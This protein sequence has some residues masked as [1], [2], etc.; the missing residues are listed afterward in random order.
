MIHL[1]RLVLAVACVLLSLSATLYAN[2]PTHRIP[3][4]L[5][6]KYGYKSLNGE[7]IIRAQFQSAEEFIGQYAIVQQRELWGI[8]NTKGAWVKDPIF[9]TLR[10]GLTS[11]SS[12]YYIASLS[13]RYGLIA[14]NGYTCTTALS[15]DYDAIY[16][17]EKGGFFT[18]QQQ[19]KQGLYNPSNSLTLGCR[20]DKIEPCTNGYILHN[21]GKLTFAGKSGTASDA[22][23]FDSI[24]PHDYGFITTINGHKGFMLPNGQIALSCNYRELIFDNEHIIA[25]GSNKCSIYSITSHKSVNEFYCDS[26]TRDEHGYIIA[27]STRSAFLPYKYLSTS[28][29]FYD[30]LTK[31]ETGYITE[32][33]GKYGHITNSGVET[34]EPMFSFIDPERMDES[35]LCQDG[36]GQLYLIENA[37][38]TSLMTYAEKHSNPWSLGLSISTNNSPET[39]SLTT[40]YYVESAESPFEEDVDEDTY[41][42]TQVYKTIKFNSGIT[43]HFV[44]HQIRRDEYYLFIKQNGQTKAKIYCN[45][46]GLT[47][48]GYNRGPKLQ[49]VTVL[50][51]GNIL[52]ESEYYSYSYNYSNFDYKYIVILDGSSFEVVNYRNTYRNCKVVGVSPNGGIYLGNSDETFIC[53]PNAHISKYSDDGE[54]MWEYYA[55]DDTAFTS[56]CETESYVYLGGYTKNRGYIG[57]QNPYIVVLDSQSGYYR[58]DKHFKIAN[59]DYGVYGFKNGKALVASYEYIN[60]YYYGGYWGYNKENHKYYDYLEPEPSTYTVVGVQH[61]GITAYGLLNEKRQWVITPVL[62]GSEPKSFGHWTIHPA[63]TDFNPDTHHLEVSAEPRVEY[64]GEYITP[65]D[66]HPVDEVAELA[67]AYAE[68]VAIEET[69][70]YAEPAE[71]IAEAAVAEED[72]KWAVAEECCCCGEEEAEW[73]IAEQSHSEFGGFEFYIVDDDTIIELSSLDDPIFWAIPTKTE[74]NTLTINDI[75]S[76]NSASSF[77]DFEFEVEDKAEVAEVEIFVSAEVMPTFKGGDLSKFRNWVQSNVKYPQS[78]LENGIQGNVVVKFVVEKDGKLSNIRVLQSPDQSLSDATIQILMKSPKWVPGKQRNKPVRV[79]YTLPVSFKL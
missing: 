44:R 73:A 11:G 47:N 63:D 5:K 51:N 61:R 29:K 79:T 42:H 66:V 6:G 59:S 20:Y 52:L 40:P 62:P 55:E 38:A 70:I 78:A 75:Y 64:C 2:S 4:E 12:T 67:I 31:T 74:A 3:F 46:I 35:Q 13:G 43:M 54:Y 22:L 60:N 8:I 53:T 25:L 65:E 23:Q 41:T 34:I 19:G 57:R 77:D 24:E 50:S 30:S 10:Y 7:V 17:D 56:L 1:Q 37:Q 32:L 39:N 21:E 58:T 18:L 72:E 36:S 9:G 16:A 68:A 49:S 28:V 26:L 69:P 15:F 33:N 14:I 27:Y 48:S 45:G 76:D 71:P